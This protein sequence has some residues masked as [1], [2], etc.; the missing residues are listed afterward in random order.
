M[1]PKQPASIHG[2]TEPLWLDQINPGMR[3]PLPDFDCTAEL[4]AG[5]AELL[6]AK[7]PIHVDPEYAKQTRFGRLIAHGPLII[8]KSLGMLGEVFG[9]ALRVMLDVGEWRF[10]GPVFVGAKVRLECFVVDVNAPK[11][12]SSGAVR[13]EIRVMAEDGGLAQRGTAS[14]LL[15]RRPKA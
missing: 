11:G 10:Y 13:L 9:E 7:H 4:V 5:Y 8:A 15:S 2:N 3:L 1:N 14:V 6:D 12:S